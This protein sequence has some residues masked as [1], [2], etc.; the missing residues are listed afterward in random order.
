MWVLLG[1]QGKLTEKVDVEIKVGVDDKKNYRQRLV[2]R[3]A[4]HLYGCGWPL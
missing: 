3:Y 4:S 2:L 1:F